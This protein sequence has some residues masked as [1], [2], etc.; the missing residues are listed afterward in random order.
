[1]LQKVN[2]TRVLVVDDS[3]L[4]RQVLTRILE[5]DPGIEVVG[6]ASDPYVARE[7]ITRKDY[8]AARLSP[9][10]TATPSQL[11]QVAEHPVVGAGLR[12][13]EQERGLGEVG[14]LG[15]ALHLRRLDPLG[16]DDH[17]HRVAEE[18]LRREDVHLLEGKSRH[19]LLGVAPLPS[20]S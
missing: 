7:E 8:D 13:P 5:S 20:N 6:A 4:V 11:A 12:G 1:M 2:K 17:G 16:A 3:A 18:R 14:P 19:R 10:R 9:W 15:D